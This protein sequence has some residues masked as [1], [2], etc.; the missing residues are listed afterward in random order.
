MHDD[1]CDGGRNRAHLEKPWSA[2]RDD[3]RKAHRLP[4][5]MK[6]IYHCG[7][8][9]TIDQ[10]DGSS[11][12]KLLRRLTKSRRTDNGCMAAIVVGTTRHR[13]LYR[14]ISYDIRPLLALNAYTLAA[15]LGYHVNALVTSHASYFCVIPKATIQLGYMLFKIVARH[16]PKTR[17]RMPVVISSHLMSHG[18]YAVDESRNN[19][20][21]TNDQS[22][23]GCD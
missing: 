3:V 6:L 22:E 20:Q 13:L 8:S 21:P 1:D 16:Q 23:V 10:L 7:V 18:C 9:I 2:F 14:F 15:A 11:G 4:Q 5:W 19:Q 17:E 12:G